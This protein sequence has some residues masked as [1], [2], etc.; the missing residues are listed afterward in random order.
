MQR[1]TVA[2]QTTAVCQRTVGVV[3]RLALADGADVEVVVRVRLQPA[4]LSDGA[5]LEGALVDAV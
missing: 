1:S 2:C 4:D 5:E 3:A